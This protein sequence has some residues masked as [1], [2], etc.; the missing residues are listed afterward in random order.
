MFLFSFIFFSNVNF[1]IA[2]DHF[3]LNSS[4][5]FMLHGYEDR[6]F[7][8]ENK[9]KNIILTICGNKYIN[10]KTPFPEPV[11]QVANETNSLLLSL[12]QRYFGKS[13]LFP[14]TSNHNLRLLT[15]DQILADIADV[16]HIYDKNCEDEKCRVLVVGSGDSGD[17]AA[18]FKLKY[19]QH[20]VGVWSS[21]GVTDMPICDTEFDQNIIKRLVQQSDEC[22][23]K[24][25]Q[26]L[27]SIEWTLSKGTQQE[28]NELLSKFD[29]PVDTHP[30]NAL[31]MFSEVFALL[32][33]L[34]LNADDVFDDY[35][36]NISHSMSVDN[37]ASYYRHI[38]DLTGLNSTSFNPSELINDSQ[39]FWLRDQRLEWFLKCTQKGRFH[40]SNGFRSDEVNEEFYTNVCKELF[41]TDSLQGIERSR[42]AFGGKQFAGT[43][44]LFTRSKDD[45]NIGVMPEPV[46]RNGVVVIEVPG[47]EESF[48]LL[49]DS[50]HQSQE[51]INA[52]NA[53]KRKVI[54]WL[55]DE[56]A[57][58]CDHGTCI[59]DKCMCDSKW[60][61]EFCTNKVLLENTYFVFSTIATIIPTLFLI[62]IGL[63]GWWTFVKS[64]HLSR[65]V[66]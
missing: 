24:T 25:A 44:V 19:P 43:N 17:I 22:Y 4:S 46:A 10:S 9:T 2:T 28:R 38:M 1:K 12:E 29:I 26:V 8:T 48:D 21:F 16:L 58:K 11:M 18:W 31:Y 54:S 39:S 45:L 37:F 64:D 3:S 47:V 5:T 15:I 6:T 49:P 53:I 7:A 61:G 33:D 40:V 35:C 42:S 66:I 20:S 50:K 59:L 62:V 65:I 34:P 52:K 60:E 27:G 30:T 41:D 56:C 32:D 13:T 23:S 57:T 14:N 63:V 55:N 51:I 36:A